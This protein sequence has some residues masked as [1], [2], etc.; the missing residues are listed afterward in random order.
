MTE[1]TRSASARWQ[2]TIDTGSG[3]VSGASGAFAGLPMSLPTRIG[4]WGGQTSPEELVAAAFASC[5]AMSVISELSTMGYEPAELDVLTDCNL[6]T[7]LN[8]FT[9]TS[10]AANV[11]AV[12]DGLAPEEIDAAVARA[13][14]KCPI[15]QVLSGSVPIQI[16]VSHPESE[17]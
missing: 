5:F 16:S 17:P 7:T 2:G 11:I 4:H 14:L 9:L 6:S 13:Y 10:L 12:V 1:I 15:G 3:S 8:E